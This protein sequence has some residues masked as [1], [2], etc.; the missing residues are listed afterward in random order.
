MLDGRSPVVRMKLMI[1]QSI[2][3]VVL[4]L[5]FFDFFLLTCQ[6]FPLVDSL[7]KSAEYGV[8]IGIAIWPCMLLFALSMYLLIFIGDVV[9]FLFVELPAFG[10]ELHERAL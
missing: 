10:I 1:A 7:A 5:D 2:K 4:S 8:N 6:N 3:I 9:H